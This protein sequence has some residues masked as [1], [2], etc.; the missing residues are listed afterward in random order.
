M[1][2]SISGHR[3]LQASDSFTGCRLPDYFR[4]MERH[5]TSPSPCY[6]PRAASPEYKPLTPFSRPRRV[7]PSS[8]EYTLTPLSQRH[9]SPDYTP[10]PGYKPALT[11]SQRSRSPTLATA[12]YTPR[13][14]SRC[15][16]P[17]YFYDMERHC[18]SPSTCYSSRAASPEYKPVTPFSRPRRTSSPEYTSSSPA[19]SDAVS[20]MSSP[21]RRRR[22]HTY[23]RSRTSCCQRRR[24]SSH[25]HGC[26]LPAIHT[27]L[28]RSWQR[29]GSPDQRLLAGICRGYSPP[30]AL[31]SF[32]LFAA[33]L[34]RLRLFIYT[35]CS[36][37]SP[38]N[39]VSRS[40]ARLR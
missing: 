11:S 22:R 15:R 27:P 16:L 32:G 29:Y 19:V 18:A 33:A 36:C 28:K 2:L 12:N 21:N 6:S 24:S 7:S 31:M 40:H 23:Q 26:Y 9:K 8:T 1:L 35:N 37:S 38:P 39:S 4:D 10:G 25:H 20:R 34:I 3:E 5:C 30:K 13:A 14:P 17:D